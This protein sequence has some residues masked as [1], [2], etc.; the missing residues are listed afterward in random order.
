MSIA[1]ATAVGPPPGMTYRLSSNE[2]AHGASPKAIAAM[3]AAAAE[4]HLY[5]DDQS[6]DLRTALASFEGVAVDQVTVA[7]GSASLLMDVMAHECGP[8]DEVLAYAHAFIVY[9]I[10]TSGAGATYVEAPDSG[11]AATDADGYQRDPAALLAAVT[12]RTRLVVIDNPGNPTGAHL[13]GDQLREVVAGIPQDVTILLDE[14]Y[15]QFATGQRGYA[16]ASELGLEHPRLLVTR[17]FSKAYALAGARVGYL[18]GPAEIIT[19][20]DAARARFNINAVAQAG[21]L[22]ALADTEH[23]QRT[24]AATIASRADMVTGLRE[25]G[26]PITD[27]LGN[28]VTIELGRPSQPVVDAFAEHEVGVRPLGPYGMA[29]QIRVS[30]GTPDEVAAFLAAARDVLA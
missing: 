18:T 20:I 12:D 5:P 4:I 14:A 25:I 19:S 16:T 21:A 2:N 30:V 13:T 28:F 1:S 7:N 17:T 22:A 29:E 8:G 15:F 26:V 3:Q 11:P 9:R 24:V 6:V 23:L 27:G 10:A